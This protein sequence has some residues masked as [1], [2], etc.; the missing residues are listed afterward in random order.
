MQIASHSHGDT[1]ILE[2]GAPRLDALNAVAAQA[3]LAQQLVPGAKRV[4]LDLGAVNYVSSAGLRTIV[5]VAKQV[6]AAGGRTALCSVQQ[7]VR[8]IVSIA[9]FD[10][11][12]PMVAG[13]AEALGAW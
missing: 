13:R 3:A 6:A 2:I 11:M 10:T 12:L 7:P 9:G 5:Q 1:L 8:E 4:V